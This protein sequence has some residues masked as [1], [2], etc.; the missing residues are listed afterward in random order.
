MSVLK[1]FLIAAIISNSFC[2]STKEDEPHLNY[3]DASYKLHNFIFIEENQIPDRPKR[4]EK[5]WGPWGKWSSCSVTCGAGQITKFRY[6]ISDGCGFDEKE[7]RVKV[8]KMN[9]CPSESCKK[10]EPEFND[11][12]TWHFI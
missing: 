9:P 10:V 7:A 2:V 12:Q 8:C 4:S 3:E 6:C 1:C 11:G 5:I